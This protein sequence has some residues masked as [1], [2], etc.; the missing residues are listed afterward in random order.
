[1]KTITVWVTQFVRPNGKR[2]RVST[3]L[4]ATCQEAYE[5][6]LRHE[7]GF[8]AE[9]LTNGLVSMAISTKDEDLDI[10]ITPNGPEVQEGMVHLL[11][12][13]SWLGKEYCG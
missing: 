5:D 1:M 3:D 8:E 12:R 9:V 10:T 11:S 2:R 4:P 6:M 7:C 13:R